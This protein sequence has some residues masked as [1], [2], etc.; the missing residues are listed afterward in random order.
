[1]KN[2]FLSCLVVGVMGL[3]FWAYTENYETK[4]K[5]DEIAQLNRDISEAHSRAYLNRPER[6][7]Q[8]VNA[9]FDELKLLQLTADHFA[10]L[11]QIPYPGPDLG[12]ITEPIEVMKREASP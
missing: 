1:M 3:A 2:L 7:L 10:R 9:N 4:G 8:L 6:L 12:P 11:E 5:L